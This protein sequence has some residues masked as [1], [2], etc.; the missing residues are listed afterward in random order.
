M[1]DSKIESKILDQVSLQNT[2]FPTYER[3][4]AIVYR[5]Q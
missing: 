1:I 5:V 4:A 3:T 2:R